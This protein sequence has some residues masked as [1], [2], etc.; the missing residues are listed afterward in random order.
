MGLRG[1]ADDARVVCFKV[2]IAD[3]GDSVVAADRGVGLVG[4]GLDPVVNRSSVDHAARVEQNRIGCPDV[5]LGAQ[6]EISRV[7]HTAGLVD[8][9]IIVDE[10]VRV[11][12][13]EGLAFGRVALDYAARS[14]SHIVCSGRNQILVDIVR[15]RYIQALRVDRGVV[16]DHRFR[17]R[18][19]RIDGPCA[20]EAESGGLFCIDQGVE[21][22]RVHGV[23]G[24]RGDIERSA[25]A[26]CIGQISQRARIRVD[27]GR[28]SR[29]GHNS[30][31]AGVGLREGGIR[32]LGRNDGGRRSGALV[33]HG[34]P[35][36]ELAASA[37]RDRVAAHARQWIE[38]DRRRA[39]NLVRSN[40]VQP[41]GSGAEGNRDRLR[42]LEGACSARRGCTQGNQCRVGVC[43]AVPGVKRYLAGIVRIKFHLVFRIVGETDV[44]SAPLHIGNNI[45]IREPLIRAQGDLVTA[46]IRR[47]IKSRGAPHGVLIARCQVDL[48][49]ILG[50]QLE[51]ACSTQ[52]GCLQGNQCRVRVCRA[53]P[54]V[55]LDLVGIRGIHF[56]LI[57]CAADEIADAG[58][59]PDAIRILKEGD[60]VS[61]LKARVRGESDLVVVAVH[62]LLG[63][64]GR[65]VVQNDIVNIS[66]GKA[67]NHRSRG[68]IDARSEI[69]KSGDVV[70]GGR[71]ICAHCYQANRIAI[72]NRLL[73]AAS[74]GIDV[75]IFDDRERGSRGHIGL[76]RSGA[77]GGAHR[78]IHADESAH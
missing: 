45:S 62:A 55:E 52:C 38:A 67:A 36:V 30:A 20:A 71:N 42:P 49:H 57:G 51:V 68:H 37:D 58:S 40:A 1:H 10:C 46:Y 64:E 54:R 66:G 47:G 59:T 48:L 12:G 24:K 56:H 44:G 78:G 25:C 15:R 27:I 69:G 7:R 53:V 72:G 5:V 14:C 61:T 60:N 11:V 8:R 33:D 41:A 35:V 50:L 70:V 21:V 23:E 6:N 43:C 28:S 19:D 77:G 65:H 2:D 3:R 29:T 39:R 17:G 32:A 76:Y 22:L 75:D 13:Y 16:A 4:I 63:I 9:H 34:L 26:C 74:H 18:V 31:G 73:V